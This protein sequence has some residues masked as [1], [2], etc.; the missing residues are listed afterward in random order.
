MK[1]L[2]WLHEW[3]IFKYWITLVTQETWLVIHDELSYSPISTF[4]LLIF[5]EDLYV[6]SYDGY[7]LIICFFKS[8]CQMLVSKLCWPHKIKC[9]A[10]NF[11]LFSG[12]VCENLELHHYFLNM[13]TFILGFLLWSIGYSEI[14]CFISK[15]ICQ[16]L[17]I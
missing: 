10:I 11:P 4:N 2:V 16:F 8:L 6:Y 14:Y 13:F 1:I 9:E 12:K 3:L 15:S 7:W 5:L 17:L